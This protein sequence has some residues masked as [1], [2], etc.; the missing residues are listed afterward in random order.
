MIKNLVSLR[1]ILPTLKH[2]YIARLKYM[3]SVRGC[4]NWWSVFFISN[5]WSVWPV[6]S[7]HIATYSLSVPK[8]LVV[9]FSPAQIPS[10]SLTLSPLCCLWTPH[11][12][13]IYN[14][15]H[16]L[17]LSMSLLLEWR[18][19]LHLLLWHY[20]NMTTSYEL[21]K[22]VMIRWN[23]NII[24]SCDWPRHCVGKCYRQ[25]FSLV[26]GYIVSVSYLK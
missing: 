2:I 24:L 17:S 13:P 25:S 22:G 3:Y 20:K 10:S 18:A 14:D 12:R 23:V 8:L 21:Y 9:F 4:I 16:C 19:P 7:T 26:L 15:R 6:T 5:C 11:T 1:N